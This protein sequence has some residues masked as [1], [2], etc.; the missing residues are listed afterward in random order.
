[1]KLMAIDA[2]TDA[3]SVAI[4]LDGRYLERAEVRPREHAD[5]LLVMVD[6]LLKQAEVRLTDLDAIVYGAGPGAFTG[7]RIAVSV[8]QGLASGAD[9]PLVPVSSLQAL[10]QGVFRQHPDA[11]K[12]FVAVDARMKEVYAGAYVKENG[13]AT[14]VGEERLLAP[15]E[16]SVTDERFDN[17]FTA[18]GSAWRSYAS[19]IPI[20]L[21]EKAHAVDV[22]RLPV[23]LDMLP[24]GKHIFT[25]GGACRPEQAQPNYLRNEVVKSSKKNKG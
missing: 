1:M 7:V 4:E 18:V 17:G 9:L 25:V 16:L 20:S 5:R 14:L 21:W 22:E 19:L 10:A 11:E 2:A 6:E 12:V 15:E 3:C 13:L 24:L 8:A 23:A